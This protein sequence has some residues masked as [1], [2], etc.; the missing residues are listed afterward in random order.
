MSSD[1]VMVDVG[2]ITGSIGVFAL[3]PTAEKAFDKVGVH[4]AWRVDHSS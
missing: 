1:K 3:V 2:T 4:S